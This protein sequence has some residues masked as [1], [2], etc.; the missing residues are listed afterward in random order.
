LFSAE[1]YLIK[2]SSAIRLKQRRLLKLSPDEAKLI[3]DVIFVVCGLLIILRNAKISFST[4]RRQAILRSFP[5][6]GMPLALY[7]ACN[8][9]KK[10]AL[11]AFEIFR[12]ILLPSISF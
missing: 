9:R 12:F 8:K 1:I 10:S 3:S 6:H 4:G 5:G 11:K 7:S 2:G